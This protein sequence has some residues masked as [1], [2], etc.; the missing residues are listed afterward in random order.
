MGNLGQAAAKA[1]PD[2]AALLQDNQAWV[3]QAAAEV[4]GVIRAT[5]AIPALTDALRDED[6][7]VRRNAAL[8]LAQMGPAAA[9]AIPALTAALDDKDEDVS[10]AAILACDRIS[11]NNFKS[12]NIP[13]ERL[14]AE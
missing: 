4:L 8:A 6:A 14:C 1:I 2:L 11:D 12:L 13:E 3:R 10:K 9:R 5:S 7:T